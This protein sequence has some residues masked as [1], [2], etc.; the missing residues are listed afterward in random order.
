MT[1]NVGPVTQVFVVG[2][3]WIVNSVLGVRALVVGGDGVFG[4]G[5]FTVHGSHARVDRVHTVS[6]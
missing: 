4:V 5:R 2:R 1:W 3:G 6:G